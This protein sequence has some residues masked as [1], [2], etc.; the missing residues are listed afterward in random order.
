MFWKKQRTGHSPHELPKQADEGHKLEESLN[1]FRLCISACSWNHWASRK[2]FRSHFQKEIPPSF[3][4]CL[5]LM[6][7]MI[8]EWVRWTSEFQQWI[9]YTMDSMNRRHIS[10][11][12]LMRVTSCC[13]C[14]SNIQQKTS[15]VIRV[16]PV[17]RAAAPAARR[18]TKVTKS[19]GLFGSEKH[20]SFQPFSDGDCGSNTVHSI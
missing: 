20:V 14:R 12:N 16:L 5:C 15:Q 6:F 3:R 11:A 18:V 19:R 2:S 1:M 9:R 7:I 13:N 10:C 17:L 8:I 4:C